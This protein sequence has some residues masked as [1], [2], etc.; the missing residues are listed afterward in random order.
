MLVVLVGALCFS[1]R[2]HVWIV[3]LCASLG[4]AFCY[5]VWFARFC[6]LLSYVVR[7]IICFF[8]VWFTRFCCSLGFVG[9]LVC[10]IRLHGPF[11]FLVR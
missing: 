1:V 4:F 9:Y 2:G 7:Q 11:G 3:L 10:I 5:F 8:V 6:S